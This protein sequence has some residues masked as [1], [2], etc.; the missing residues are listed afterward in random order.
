MNGT[1]EVE[2]GCTYFV[3]GDP[4]PHGGWMAALQEEGICVQVFPSSQRF[5]DEARHDAPACV[6]VDVALAEAAEI[7]QQIRRH[8]KLRM[9]V[10][11][12]LQGAD[13]P[14]A[15]NFMKLGAF[16]LIAQP[17][18]ANDLTARIQGGIAIDRNRRSQEAERAA[19]NERL[20]TLTRRERELLS[21]VCNGL[22]NKQIAASLGISVKTVEN[23]RDRV[24]KKT[25]AQN[26]ADLV[27]MTL[28]AAG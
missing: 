11:V 10:I 18:D 14:T 4:G 15:V 5:V 6:V 2:T 23:H 26:A 3:G 16:D 7:L 25:R 17:V 8:I 9:P 1:S 13:I 20:E 21:M 22:S 12:L 28:R 19:I 24:M 27:R